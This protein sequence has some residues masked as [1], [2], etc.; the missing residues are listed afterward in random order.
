MG[1]TLYKPGKQH[2][3][4]GIKCEAKVFDEQSYLQ[5]LDLGWYYSPAD[6]YEPVAVEELEPIEYVEEVEEKEPWETDGL[7]VIDELSDDEIRVLAK[8]KGI[9]N[10]YNKGIDKLK[11][12]IDEWQQEI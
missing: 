9:K 2:T 1:I 7:I 12:E 5:Y 4:R 11:R 8:E 6:C 10:W 3:V